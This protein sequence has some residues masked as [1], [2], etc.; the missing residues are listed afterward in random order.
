MSVMTH[1]ELFDE[2]VEAL[3]K[4]E[5]K[6]RLSDSTNNDF[7]EASEIARLALSN[8]DKMDVKGAS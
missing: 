1:E 7:F 8:V 4:I 3:R 2:L 5:E 6:F